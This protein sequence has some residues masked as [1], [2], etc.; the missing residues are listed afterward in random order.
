MGLFKLN[1]LENGG[2]NSQTKFGVHITS[3]IL[4]ITTFENHWITPTLPD[5]PTSKAYPA[6]GGGGR[7][8]F[9]R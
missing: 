6:P 7:L 9:F 4:K 3:N 8:N 5:L 2:S 1:I